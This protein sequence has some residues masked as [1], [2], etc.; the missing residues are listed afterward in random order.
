VIAVTD[1]DIQFVDTDWAVHEGPQGIPP[2]KLTGEGLPYLRVFYRSILHFHAKA[3]AH[4]SVDT[5]WL[6]WLFHAGS[7]AAR[8]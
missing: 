5:I 8:D 6:L 7:E 4:A 1:S 3:P 2:G